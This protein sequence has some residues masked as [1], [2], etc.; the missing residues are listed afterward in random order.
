L[1]NL[2]SNAIKFTPEGGNIRLEVKLEPAWPQVNQTTAILFSVMD[3]GI[4]I[5]PENIHKLFQS[6]VQIDT[7]LNRQYSGTGLGLALVKQITELHGGSISVESTLGQGSCFTVKLSYQPAPQQLL[8]DENQIQTINKNQYSRTISDPK[9]VA[10]DALI[11]LVE[12]NEANISTVS[13]YLIS[14]GYRLLVARSGTKAITLAQTQKPQLILMDIQM[15][16]MDGL[17]A[18]RQIR[19]DKSLENIPIIALT[20]LAMPGDREQC[21]QA[22]INEYLSKPVR[23]KQLVD[24]IQSFLDK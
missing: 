9:K 22:G 21:I 17:E 24:T 4:G 12:D 6:F 2:L 1:I 5:A 20:A 23:L 19:A 10:A 15:P 7:K 11:L 18:S 8:T 14:R 13:D 3:T 16:G